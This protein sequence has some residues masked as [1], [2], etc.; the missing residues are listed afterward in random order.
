MTFISHLKNRLSVLEVGTLISEVDPDKKMIHLSQY[1]KF[2]AHALAHITLV[3][4]ATV[5]KILSPYLLL[6]VLTCMCH[7][8][9]PPDQTSHQRWA[10]SSCCWPQLVSRSTR[11][12]WDKCVGSLDCGPFPLQTLLW[13]SPDGNLALLKQKTECFVLCINCSSLSGSD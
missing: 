9:G 5:E 12:S 4:R 3:Q 8:R 2:L 1:P 13:S 6:Y 7:L 11:Y 10:G